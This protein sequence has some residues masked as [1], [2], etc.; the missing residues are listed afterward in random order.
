MCFKIYLTCILFCI[1]VM[2]YSQSLDEI[3]VSY[4]LKNDSLSVF[5]KS[6]ENQYNL[7]IFYKS[8]WIENGK[9]KNSYTNTLLNE[10][11]S[12]VL[13]YNK[14]TYKIIQDKYIVIYPGQ[15]GNTSASGNSSQIIIIGD[16]INSGRY[17]TATLTGKITDGK[18]REPLPGAV[19]YDNKLDKG[20]STDKEGNFSLILPTGEHTLQLSFMGFEQSVK[21]I[22][23][24]ESGY[25]EFDLFEE[26][27]NLEEVTV[28][29]DDYNVS[30][31]Q[32]SIVKMDAKTIKNLPLLLGERDIIKSVAMMPGIQTVS[33][34]ASGFNV[35]GGNADQNLILLN[36]SPV[37]NISHLFGFLSMINPDVVENLNVYKGALPARYGERVSSVMEIEMKNGNEDHLK[38]Y[39][40]I[41]ILNSRLAI[42]GPLNKSKKLTV[43]LGG[44]KS[45]TDW[46]L[47]KIPD[48]DISNSITN[49]Y[50]FSGKLAYKFNQNN[51]MEFMAYSSNDEFSTSAQSVNDYGNLLFNLTSHFRFSEQ[52]GSELQLAYSKYF[53]RLTDF[54]DGKNY[55][56]YFL[57]NQIQYQS[58]KYHL[59]WHPHPNHTIRTGI[60]AIYYLNDPG[61]ITPYSNVTIIAPEKLDREKALESAIYA[62]DEFNVLPDLTMNM[63][64][65]YSHFALIGPETV[66]IYEEGKTK[67]PESVT[68]TKTFGKGDVIK[69]YGNI[70]P[71][72]SLNYL[73]PEGHSLKMSYQRISQYINQISNNAVISPAEI[74]KTSDYHLKP[75]INNQVAVSFASNKL[76]KGIDFST[77]VYFK[78]LKNLIEYKNG[79]KIIMNQHLET[80]LIPSNGYSYG[81]EFSLKK[82]DGRLTGWLNYVYSRTMRKTTGEF[83]EEQIN[84]GK[85][86]PSIYDK[87]HDLSI[88]ATY[89]ISRRWRISGNFV[90]ISGRPVT[91]PEIT[92]KYAGETIVYYSDRNKYRMQPYH[93]FDVS[94]TFDENL[95][96][97]RMWKGS[98]TLS[99]YNLYGRN[100]PYSVYYR[101]TVGSVATDY[102]R[103][104]LFKL[105]VI[106]IPVPSLT[107]N[108]T[109]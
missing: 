70:E 38:M 20:T 98:W 79:A 46:I 17:K 37:F 109:F 81:M 87:P 18:N 93:R 49:F 89:N 47:E 97:K 94:I 14:L 35:R 96:K 92:Y 85:Y 67:S 53:F 103:Y 64:L 75:L 1:T 60:N 69:S 107:Y 36:G 100:N 50:D 26:S 99:V 19:I 39:G 34:L 78:A 29:A 55:E 108:F 13:S 68:D 62:S 106:G 88:A 2:G 41:G 102:R 32:M 45:Y 61:E 43:A 5:L 59:N 21:K 57:D 91:L 16:I 84:S 31:T 28:V 105:S 82:N 11:F 86:F 52:T 77:E 72:F 27:H 33:E 4:N 66:L 104:S 80:D 63:G 95:R 6:L 22:N 15:F 56:A 23:L 40:G 65:R 101:K 24:V 90:Y 71:R 8:S 25:V 10:V 83:E 48:P 30:K 42:D 51:W 9:I 7:K 73:T 54:T 76:L 58:L 12:E 74:W 3:P 44:R